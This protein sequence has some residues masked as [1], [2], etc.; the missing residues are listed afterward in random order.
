MLKKIALALLFISGG[1]M[2]VERATFLVSKTAGKLYCGPDYMQPVEGYIGTMSC[3]YNA[4][5]YV[6][7]F[8]Y[9][10]MF[11]GL[12]SFLFGAMRAVPEDEQES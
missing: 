5:V 1:F 8:L 10:G 9:T 7:I 4:D 12:F 6:T 2:L 11:I 3:G